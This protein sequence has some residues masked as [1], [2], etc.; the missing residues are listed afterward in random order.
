MDPII[1]PIAVVLGKYALDKG[2]ELVKE[3][4]PKA[5]ETV[6][7]MFAVALD[8]LRREPK[9][10][11]IAGEFEQDPE[12]YQK[13]VEK[14]LDAEVQADPDFAAQLKVL[15]EQYETAAQEHAAATGTTYQATV[16]G[17]GAIAQGEGA[18]AAGAGGI[19]VG[20]DVEGGIR[21]TGRRED[22][23]E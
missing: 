18:V 23:D 3:V 4:G 6:K 15:L 16:K 20:G 14:A 1:T 9:G 22:K 7:E 19:A 10:E 12:T 5:L 13:P 21:I 11:V 17:S 2:G 8:R